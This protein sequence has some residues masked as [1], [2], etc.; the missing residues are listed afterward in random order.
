MFGLKVHHWTALLDKSLIGGF[1]MHVRE[2][3]MI[4]ILFWMVSS[5]MVN[6]R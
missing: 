6:W 2:Y 1:L 5:A 3:F 4:D